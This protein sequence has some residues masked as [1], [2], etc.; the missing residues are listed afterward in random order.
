MSASV[1]AVQE[2]SPTHCN[3]WFSPPSSF[4]TLPPHADGKNSDVKSESHQLLEDVSLPV[5]DP[6]IV[7][8]VLVVH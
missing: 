6:V 1:T 2:S 7:V 5:D 4:S 8:I 3:L